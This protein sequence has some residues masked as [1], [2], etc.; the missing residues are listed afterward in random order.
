MS[1]DKSPERTSARSAPAPD[2][3]GAN[4]GP[5]LPPR[6]DVAGVTNANSAGAAA[7]T[8]ATRDHLVIKDWAAKRQAQP[9][10]GESTSTGPHV[11]LHVVDGGAGL[12]F[13]FPGVASFRPIGWDE[14]LAHFDRHELLFVFENDGAQAGTRGRPPGLSGPA[15][16]MSHRYRLVKAHDWDGAIAG[17]VD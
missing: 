12:R 2:G 4:E 6:P 10:T 11:D 1:A 8:L 7:S 14:W 17:A 9:A 13:N 16:A 3:A 15:G 5:L